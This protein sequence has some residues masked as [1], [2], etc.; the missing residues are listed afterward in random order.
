MNYTEN[1]QLPQ[2]EESDRILMADFNA[3]M[4]NIDGAIAEI[5]HMVLG[6]YTGDGTASRTISLGFTPRAV[7]VVASDGVPF[8]YVNG[9]SQYCGGLV[10]QGEHTADLYRS[11]TILEICEGGFK[12]GYNI[13]SSIYIFSNQENMKYHYIALK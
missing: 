9:T 10:F 2:W 1:Y 3:A 4:G 8:R 12:V 7:L 13:E 11:R 6:S 5:P